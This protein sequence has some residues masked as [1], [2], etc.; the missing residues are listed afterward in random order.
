MSEANASRASVV[1]CGTAELS[2]ASAS[3]AGERGRIVILGLE[4]YTLSWNHTRK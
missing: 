2:S 3:G 1:V 4:G